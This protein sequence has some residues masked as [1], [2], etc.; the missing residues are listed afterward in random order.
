MA[1]AVAALRSSEGWQRWLRVRRHFHSYS[2][3]NQLL[4]AFQRPDATQVA[5][6]KRWLAVG[7]RVRRGEHGIRI[8]APCPPSKKRLRAWAEEGAD[9]ARRPRT[10]FRMVAVFDRSQVDPLPDFPGEPLQ[11]D[12]PV[13]PLVG[14]GLA[15]CSTPC[16]SSPPQSARGSRSPRSPA[17]PTATS[18]RRRSGSRSKRAAPTSQPTPRSR[19]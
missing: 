10:F 3:H 15:P 19:S 7:Y 18:S 9:P 8:W 14:D 6:Y 17:A 16:A 4:I 5:G 13:E 12:P 2:F 11:L 1:E